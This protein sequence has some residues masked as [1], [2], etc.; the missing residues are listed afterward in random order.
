[1]VCRG[2][3]HS[4]G[5]GSTPSRDSIAIPMESS[6]RSLPIGPSIAKPTGSRSGVKPAGTDRP[7]MPVILPGSVLRM[8]VKKVSTGGPP[9]ID[10]VDEPFTGSILGGVTITVG[11]RAPSSRLS[12]K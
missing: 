12:A 9:L 7:G 8:L 11:K 10:S 2:F 3:L 5:A 6:L 1:M 4:V